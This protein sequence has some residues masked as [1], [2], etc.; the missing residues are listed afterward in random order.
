MTTSV[1]PGPP[2]T[3][4]PAA[5]PSATPPVP[6][7]VTAPGVPA[8]SHPTLRQRLAELT[9]TTPGRLRVE[10][11]LLVALALI[12]GLFTA[13]VVNGRLGATNRIA[14][15][16]VPV[17]VSARQVQTGL[18]EANAAAATA[19]LA[20]GVENADQRQLY[21]DSIAAVGRE[22]ENAARLTGDDAEA[23]EA[24]QTL[25]SG[26]PVYSGLI[27]QARAN[28]RQGFPV[29]AAYL[30]A[31]S[32][33][34]DE[35]LFP[36][37]D[38]VANRAAERYRSAYDD[39]R[40]VSLVLALAA[41]GLNLL[42][43]LFLA[44]LLLQLQR[45]FR[46]TLNLPLLA[47]LAVAVALTGWLG[48]GLARQSS[49]LAAART[50]GYQGTRLYLDT[51]G[52]AF[53]AKADEARYLL[54]RGAGQAFEDDFLARAGQFDDLATRIDDHVAATGG[55]TARSDADATTSAWERYT[56]AHAALIEQDAKGER[57]AAV[58]AALEEATPAFAAF[59]DASATAL[60]HQQG[61][62]A[63]EMDQAAGAL[64]GLRVGVL[65]GVVLL[66]AA[67]A[68]GL[69]QRIN[70]YR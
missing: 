40:G 19:F 14:E 6:G 23:H 26:L 28:N 51:R 62:F 10:S 54:A 30:N 18:A 52:A 57:A 33:L 21:E 34:L 56:Q 45:R 43:V 66:A 8:P 2:A 70:E 35:Q 12:T 20:G 36:A 68:Y 55:A 15:E 13:W 17:I 9:T 64:G 41:V 38:V 7:P 25:T 11:V 39:Q 61:E 46:R 37:T 53:G 32:R 67:G 47:A 60:D 59:D 1:A 48:S 44:R 29:S 5:P 42:V 49:H 69:Q 31:A 58:T 4:P 65:L 3:P 16:N 24:L 50:D 63:F 27:E 22:L